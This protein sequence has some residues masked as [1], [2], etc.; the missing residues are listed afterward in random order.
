MMM[1]E[2]AWRVPAA[3][4]A[5]VLPFASRAVSQQNFSYHVRTEYKLEGAGSPGN[6]WLDSAARRLYVAHGDRVEVLNADTGRRESSMAAQD[7]AGILIAAGTG[8]GFFANLHGNS[9]TMFDPSTLAIIKQ[10]PLAA[11]GP[12]SITYDD[13]VHKVFVVAPTSGKVIALDGQSG[14]VAGTVALEGHLRQAVSN[15]YGSLFVAAQDANVIHVV[16][17]HT[18]KF[19]GDIPTGD[20]EGPVSLAIDPSGRR[21]FVACA[22]G[23]LPVIDT[24]IGFPFEELPIGS[25]EAGSFFTFNPQGKGGWKGADFVASDDGSLA[26]VKMNAFIN[27]SA[28]RKISIPRGIHDVTYDPKTHEV[29]LTASTPTPEVIVMAPE[30][31][32]EVSQ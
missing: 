21:L 1:R 10:I 23:K 15:G 14:E 2:F 13:D 29:Y 11:A 16:D 3:A 28:G 20:A 32:A 24:D 8:H 25:G 31:I 19:L 26:L 12:E 17:T 6:L 9:V 22:D 27:Y 4:L 7:A 5:M 30:S 18:L